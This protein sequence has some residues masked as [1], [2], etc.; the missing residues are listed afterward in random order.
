MIYDNVALRKKPQRV[1]RFRNQ[2]EL[3]IVRLVVLAE[4]KGTFD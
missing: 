3:M 2:E 4:W 1:Y